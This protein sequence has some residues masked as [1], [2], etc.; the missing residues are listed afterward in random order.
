MTSNLL[1]VTSECRLI[2]VFAFLIKFASDGYK[3]IFNFSV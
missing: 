3:A 1:L 2:S